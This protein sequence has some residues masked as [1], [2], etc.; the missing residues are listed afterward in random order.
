MAPTAATWSSL[1]GP[2]R[3]Y[4]GCYFFI[5]FLCV[6]WVPGNDYDTLTSYITRI[7]L[8]EFGD[9]HQTATLELQYLFPKFFDYLHKPLLELGYFTTLPSFVLFFA[10]CLVLFLPLTHRERLVCAVFI[11]ACPPVLVATTSFKNDLP[12]ACF[13][14]LAWY[15]IFIR[16]RSS[17]YLPFALLALAALAGTKW[18][19]F[20]LI[21]PLGIGL[22]LSTHAYT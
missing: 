19:G 17:S 12:L 8:E 18:H 3:I 1:P 15:A 9:L 2:I 4:L 6:F 22:N 13:G 5:L 11:M 21:A 20:F 7:K 10:G 16:S 14:L